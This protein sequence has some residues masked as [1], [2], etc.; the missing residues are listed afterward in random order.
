LWVLSYYRSSEL[1]GALLFGRLARRVTDPE[2]LMFLTSHFAEEA[3]HAAIWTETIQRCG[4]TP[5]QIA[6]TYQSL[7]G[8]RVGIPATMAEV[9]LLT[10]VFEERIFSHFSKHAA[11][12]DVH[13]IVKETLTRMLADEESH[14]GWIS[15]RLQ[16]YESEG[17]LRLGEAR[18]RY[19]AI[20]AAIY[21]EVSGS[22]MELQQFLA[23]TG[24]GAHRA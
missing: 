21:E 20:D 2:L 19:R 14:I 4:G 5:V 7:Y 11:R 16:R 24:A 1:A 15:E 9:L 10:E 8:A 3:R 6:N 17:V 18:A 12:A 13:P 22:E 23:G